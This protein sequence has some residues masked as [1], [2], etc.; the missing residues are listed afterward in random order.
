MNNPADEQDQRTDAERYAIDLE[1]RVRD[2]R[3]SLAAEKAR[4]AVVELRA[5]RLEAALGDLV[6]DWESETVS[7]PPAYERARAVLL[8]KEEVVPW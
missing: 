7:E 4:R 6:R 3:E 8:D 2:L 1:Q 5:E